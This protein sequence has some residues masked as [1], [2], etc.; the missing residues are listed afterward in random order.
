M[1]NDPFK[2]GQRT[3]SQHRQQ[4]FD[5]QVQPCHR[6]IFS[7]KCD[8]DKCA[9]SHDPKL[10]MEKRLQAAALSKPMDG[11]PSNETR[12]PRA[13]M[14]AAMATPSNVAPK[15]SPAILPLRMVEDFDSGSDGDVN[16]F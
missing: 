6:L 9:F 3:P 5:I 12:T 10:V 14:I 7:G 11:K 15:S 16:N 2:P 4:P 1:N 8:K 13:Q